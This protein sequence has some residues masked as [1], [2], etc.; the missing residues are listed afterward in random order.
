M[1]KGNQQNMSE[2]SRIERLTVLFIENA[3]N[4]IDMH[5]VGYAIWQAI[6]QC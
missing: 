2:K 6:R 5:S 4:A 1:I 3:K